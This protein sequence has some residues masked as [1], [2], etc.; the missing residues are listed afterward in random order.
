[1]KEGVP[2]K[3]I[4]FADNQPCIELLEKPPN[5]LLR[6]L[7][8]QCK[9]PN[10]TE[11]TFCKELNRIHGKGGFLAPTRTQRMRDEEGFIVRHF[12]GD[13]V[14]HTSLM[15][16]KATSQQEVPWLDKNN[17]TLQSEMVRV[18]EQL[19]RAPHE[20]H[21]RGGVHEVA[22]R[23]RRVARSAPSRSSS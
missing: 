14:Y 10:A 16:A 12:A 17:D 7:D 19:E 9:T 1:M 2:W 4:E 21:V 5:G 22:E 15:I 6:L 20:D 3:D 23:T 11:E 18:A 13:V 8:S